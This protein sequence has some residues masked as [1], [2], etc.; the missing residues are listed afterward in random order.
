MLLIKNAKIY[1][2]AD[3]VIDKGDILIDNG[4][5][6][7]I[8]QGLQEENAEVL[9]AEGLIALPGLVDCHTHVGGMNFSQPTHN[10]DLNE[11]TN[12]ITPDVQAIYGTDTDSQDF[13]Y[14]YKNGITTIAITPGSGNVVCGWV[15]ATKTYGKN[16]FEMVIK[17]PVALKVALGGN[18]KGTYGKRNQEPSTRMSIPGIVKNLLRQAKEYMDKKEEAYKENKELPKHD[19]KLEAVIPVLKKEIPLKIHCTQFDMLTAMEIAREFD[20]NFTLDHAWGASEYMEEIVESGCGI[21]F[22]PIGS[23]K[24]FGEA[25]LIDIESV[26]ELDKR[27]VLT[28]LITDAPILSIDSLIHHAGEAVREGCEVERALRMITI[29]AAKI[30]GVDDRVGSIEVGKDADISLFKGLPTYNTNAKVM[31]TIINGNI[32]YSA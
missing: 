22:G 5:I 20:V 21:A 4:K 25:K 10:D 30:M 27:G 16:I 28:A 18:P 17:N 32:V 29:N 26:V 24:S 13:E 19:K 14:A 12:N 15:F 23:M 9:D 11:M 7:K 1:T 31:H 3:K 2:M 6:L 8:G